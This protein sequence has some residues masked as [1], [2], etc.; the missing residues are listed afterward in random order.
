MHRTHAGALLGVAVPLTVPLG[1]PVCG[2]LGAAL[3]MTRSVTGALAAAAG[4]AVLFP[5]TIP[6]L[7]LA[8]GIFVA[9]RHLCPPGAITDTARARL[10]SWLYLSERLTWKGHGAGSARVALESAHVRSG[11][12]AMDGGPARN[13]A[14]ELAYEY[15]AVGVA[16]VLVP[17]ALTSVLIQTH[18]RALAAALVAGLVAISGTSP[19]RAF[20]RWLRGGREGSLWGPPLRA[21]LTIHLDA[22]NQVHLYGGSTEDRNLKIEIARAFFNLGAGW[23]D[24]HG[25]TLEEV[26]GESRR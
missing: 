22:D 10:L 17:I 8:V 23:M 9:W 19:L 13:E 2:V 25:L 18:S 16:I 4:L 14:L 5:W 3:L 12:L 24:Q 1:W 7:L 11:G 15:G 21:S 20:S 6:M 26:Q